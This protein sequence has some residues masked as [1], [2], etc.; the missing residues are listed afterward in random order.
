MARYNP[1]NKPRELSLKE[2]RLMSDSNK[3]IAGKSLCWGVDNILIDTFYEGREVYDTSTHT[4]VD[5]FYLK[6]SSV[7]EGMTFKVHVPVKDL[8]DIIQNLQDFQKEIEEY[9]ESTNG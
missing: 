7:G 1:E 6:L 8:K 4:T 9:K 3:I 2:V 5:T